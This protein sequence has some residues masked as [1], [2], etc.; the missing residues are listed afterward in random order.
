MS[1]GEDCSISLWNKE[2]GSLLRKTEQESPA[3]LIDIF[4]NE[5]TSN[6]II[7]LFEKC[8]KIFSSDTLELER[9]IQVAPSISVVSMHVDSLKILL[10]GSDG[11]IHLYYRWQE[12]D[13][14]E[15]TSPTAVARTFKDHQ[16]TISGIQAD[17]DK[18]ITCSRD[19]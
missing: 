8:V 12:I 19:G 4:Y 18:M 2:D 3:L 14:G 10:G 5:D 7:C 11:N 9:E 16:S 6:S 17:D 13:N 15:A 1:S